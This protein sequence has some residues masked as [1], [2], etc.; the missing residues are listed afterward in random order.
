M[1]F[2]FLSQKEKH[3]CL[4]DSKDHCTLWRQ[5]FVRQE[6]V[7]TKT[8]LSVLTFQQWPHITSFRVHPPAYYCCSMSTCLVNTLFFCL[9]WSGAVWYNKIYL[10]NHSLF[11]VGFSVCEWAL[12][13]NCYIIVYI[14]YRDSCWVHYYFALLSVF[15]KCQISLQCASP[16]LWNS[17]KKKVLIERTVSA[18]LFNH[19]WLWE[20]FFQTWK[21]FRKTLWQSPLVM[22]K[23]V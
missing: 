7:E 13:W 2:F 23:Y 17:K 19:L 21:E 9:L 1:F 12:S 22:V 3:I 6:L 4:I 11:H 10:I 18:Q 5:F 14:I 8:R 16:C 20:W 15:I